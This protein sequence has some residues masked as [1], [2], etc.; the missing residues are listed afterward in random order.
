[1]EPKSLLTERKQQREG[2]LHR[3]ATQFR[4]T[5]ELWGFQSPTI[6]HHNKKGKIH[7]S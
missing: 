3:A 5:I 7:E 6:L 2:K 4:L 1:M